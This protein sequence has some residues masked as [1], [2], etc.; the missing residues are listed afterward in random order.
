MSDND[1][2]WRAAVANAHTAAE[3]AFAYAVENGE[4]LDNGADH[5]AAHE[6]ADSSEWVIYYYRSQCLWID[7]QEVRDC[8]PEEDEWQGAVDI[9]SRM[10]ACVYNAL[11]DEFAGHW[12]AL[13]EA[14]ENSEGVTA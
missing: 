3:E 4:D 9:Q 6:F 8:E 13:L 7:S 1:Y 5:D 10:T 12:R 2:T 11:A 14:H